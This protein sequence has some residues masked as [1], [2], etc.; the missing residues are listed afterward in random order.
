MTKNPKEKPK[1]DIGG[2]L[3]GVKNVA[4]AGHVSPDGDCIGSCLGLYTYITENFPEVNADVYM[5]ELPEIYRFINGVDKIISCC[6]KE[7]AGKYDAIIL[8][9]ISSYDRIGVA[10]PIFDNIEKTI[11]LDHHRT[12]NGTYTYFYND[13]DASST[14]E[15][16]YRFLDPEKI[17]KKCAEAIYMG[18]VHDT[19][20]FR[21]QSTSPET[22]RTAAALMEKGIDFSRI[23]DETFYE[24]THTQQVILGRILDRSQLYLDGRLII[25]TVSRKER[26]ELKLK[27]SDLDGIV[28]QLRNTIGVEVSVLL[29]ELDN[30]EFKASFRSRDY[31][32]VSDI[33]A[34][35]GGGGH[36]RAAGCK[37]RGDVDEIAQNIVKLV[38][39]K[40]AVQ[41][42]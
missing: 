17:S 19:G 37:M 20:V 16:L 2:L 12:N 22:M 36:I 40:M 1:I 38:E 13:P 8:L 21:Y 26:T 5:Q 10:F 18:I 7:N 31:V 23:V 14:S 41:P 28:S 25:G 34:G 4:I 29:Y 42:S 3:E 32:D 11:C 30:G 24:K 6:R 33:C 39:E 9:D 15:V 27:A 35:F